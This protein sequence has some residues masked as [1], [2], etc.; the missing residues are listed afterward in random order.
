M[1]ELK[2]I[3]NHFNQLGCLTEIDN[4]TLW[5]CEDGNIGNFDIIVE[6]EKLPQPKFK[7][8]RYDTCGE[9]QFAVT[10]RRFL[11]GWW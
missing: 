9:T 4:E 2:K 5:I 10:H 6:L 8:Q 1:K 7:W 3:Q 11:N